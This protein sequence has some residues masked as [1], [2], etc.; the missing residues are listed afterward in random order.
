MNEEKQ[1]IE[2]RLA[3]E[4]ATEFIENGMTVG[5]GT[6]STVFYAIIKL[7]SL[8][9][10]GLM[11]KAVSTSDATTQ[12]AQSL[13]ITLISVDEV[14]DIDLTIDGADEVDKSLNGIKGGGGALLFEKIVALSSK[15]NIWVIDSNKLVDKLG[16]F[17]LP[18]EVV[19]YGY[20]RVLKILEERNL[21]P[22]IRKNG[23]ENYFTDSGNYIF[24]LHLDEINNPAKLDYDLKLITGVIETGLFINVVDNIIIGKD[25]STEMIERKD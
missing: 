25:D 16:K 6:G 23:S 3:A 18:V 13:G 5:L 10:N 15:R 21:N 8:V 11:I 19:P 14:N 2:K 12:L 17:P 9:K 1:N 4:K 22:I 7:G 20:R 24:D